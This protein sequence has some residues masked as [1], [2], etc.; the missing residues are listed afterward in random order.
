VKTV[1]FSS[2][3]KSTDFKFA[4]LKGVSEDKTV[5]KKCCL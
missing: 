4:L 5:E 3:A 1:S 2:P